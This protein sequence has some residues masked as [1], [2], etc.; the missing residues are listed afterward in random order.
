MDKPWLRC[1]NCRY[2][3]GATGAAGFTAAF[4][5]LR[6]CFTAGLAVA[7][8]EVPLVA[9]LVLVVPA[10]FATGAWAGFAAMLVLEVFAVGAAVVVLAVVVIIGLAVVAAVAGLAVAGL[11]VLVW[12]KAPTA[13]SEQAAT[14]SIFF[15][16][17]KINLVRT[18][19][20]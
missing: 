9:V 19:V 7:V 2:C 13:K 8:V 15:M 17:R 11:V 18:E 14:M 4:L 12:A 20:W 5:C 3:L 10:G 16:L 6:W 1:I